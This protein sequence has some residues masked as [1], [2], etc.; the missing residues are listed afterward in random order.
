[1]QLTE[2]E[3]ERLEELKKHP[4]K[5]ALGH[6]YVNDDGRRMREFYVDC[7]DALL[8][9]ISPETAVFGGNLSFRFPTGMQPLII[10]GQD[11]MIACQF[12]F[13][14]KSWR[15]PQGESLIL[16]K[17]EG[18][19]I[20]VSAFILRKP[21][22]GPELTDKQLA[23]INLRF[24]AGKEH[25]SKEEAISLF[26]SAAK[27]PITRADSDDDLVDSPFL[28]MFGNGQAHNVFGRIIT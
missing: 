5:K 4:L 20:M 18:E 22:L 11:K 21:G 6:S 2:A 8:A 9:F 27:R 24:R 28:K 26:G 13:S 15:G 10:V 3:A 12:L 25:V 1:V 7:H 19:G 23:E 14:A 17:G 16:P